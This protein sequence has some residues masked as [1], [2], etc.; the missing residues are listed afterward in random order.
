MVTG[1][2]LMTIAHG[3]KHVSLFIK[4]CYQ[5]LCFPSNKETLSNKHVSWSVWTD[6]KHIEKLN[7]LLTETFKGAKIKVRS[8][9]K[10][11]KYTDIVQSALIHQIEDCLETKDRFLMAPP[12]T[13]FSDKSLANLLNIP[14]KTGICFA[15]PH[16][17]VLPSVLEEN[18]LQSNTHSKHL[19]R[20]GQRH[21]H[22]AWIQAEMGH[23]EQSS[24]IG[25]IW[26]KKLSSTLYAVSHKLPTIYLIDFTLADLEYFKTCTSSGDFDHVWPQTLIQQGRYKYIGS[27]DIAFMLEITEAHKNVPPWTPGQPTDGTFWQNHGHNQI[28]DCFIAT[29]R[30]AE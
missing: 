3:D 28:N 29:Y 27:S 20:L 15:I 24:F 11:R 8:I 19:F 4:A 16:M 10:L 5:S 7:A 1:L 14:A 9:D 12:D 30:G 6:N 17:R 25:G 23:P 22:R 18:T 2:Q 21:A 26:W 13:I